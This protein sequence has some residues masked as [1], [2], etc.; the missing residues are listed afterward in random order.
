M[1]DTAITLVIELLFALVF[2]AVLADYVRRRDPLS[3]DLVLVFGSVAMLFV[4]QFIGIVF[5]STPAWLAVASG[6]LILAQP[7]FTLRL[8]ARL[9]HVPGAVL[10][11][12]LV[13]YLVTAIPLFVL[14]KPLP[15]A[16]ALAAVSVFAIT[17]F[18]AAGYLAAE[19]RRRIGI[20]KF[21]LAVAA[22]ATALFAA[23]LLTAG[24]GTA[25]GGTAGTAIARFVALLAAVGYAV[26]FLPPGPLRRVWQGM[27]A[28]RYGLA[29]LGT[30][31]DAAG[32][33][34][35]AAIWARFAE[36]AREIAGAEAA[37]VIGLEGE[38]SRVVASTGID[39]SDGAS[40]WPAGA[41]GSLINDSHTEYRRPAVEMS[42]IPRHLA[43]R[44]GTALASV[45]AT[46][47]SGT[48]LVLL[49]Q[50]RSLFGAEDRALI[51]LLAAQADA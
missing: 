43:K 15:V 42:D 27:A 31:R 12:A 35:S 37:A 9:R 8:T 16:L 26:A 11:A 28:Y 14:P 51:R 50:H 48:A 29:M 18:V 23:A 32:Q 47:T 33:D 17:E 3:R 22:A 39:L 5:G 21:R 10:G 30:E 7:L 25:G 40:S 36:S 20:A 44:S 46:P 49:A 4:V 38:E 19:A 24:A 45:L 2:V 1:L 41:Y 34:G 6:M 13:G